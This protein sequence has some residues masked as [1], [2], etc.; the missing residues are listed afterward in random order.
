MLLHQLEEAKLLGTGDAKVR[1][2]HWLANNTCYLTI[3]GSI[4]YG[5]AD[6]NADEASDFDTIGVCIPP[7][8]LTFPQYILGFDPEPKVE[9]GDGSGVY[10][11]HHINDPSARGGKGRQYDLNIYSITK[12]FHECLK[13]NP[14][15][16]DSLFTRQECVLHCTKAGNILRE[17]RKM[18]LSKK[19][20]NTYKQYAYSQL[21]K[22]KGKNPV[23]KRKDQRDKYGYDLK[24]AY[25]LV[26]LLEECDQILSEGDLDLMRSKELLKTIRRGEWTQDQVEEYCCRKEASLETIYS[27]SELPSQ[28][29]DKKVRRVL[30]EILEHHYGSLDKHLPKE[31]NAAE[32]LITQ[33]KQLIRDRGF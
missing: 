31:P 28:P 25:N 20:W 22:M 24:F 21:H 4:S 16:I 2:P 1:T 6:T 5:C 19:C 15:L 14:N 3:S 17:N 7:K 29:D 18:F 26:R 10:E 8:E 11:E 32:D 13:C 23:G 12:F 9:P 33:L 27:K 30:I